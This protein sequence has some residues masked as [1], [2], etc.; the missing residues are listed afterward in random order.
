MMASLLPSGYAAIDRHRYFFDHAACAC[1]ARAAC[2][3][4]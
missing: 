4:N 3:V 1:P 2:T